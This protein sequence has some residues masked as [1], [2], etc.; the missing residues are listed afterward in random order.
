[1]TKLSATIP[2]A[3][4]VTGIM[5]TGCSSSEAGAPEPTDSADT[6][7]A[8]SDGASGDLPH[9]GAPAV[10]QPIDTKPW[11]SDPCS[12]I[13]ASQFSSIGFD[14][15]D[16]EQ[17]HNA[18]SGPT[19][20]WYPADATLGGFSG[21]FATAQPPSEGLSRIYEKRQHGEYEVWQELD[22]IAGHPVVRAES[23]DDADQ[24]EC[25]LA[26]GLRD[27]LVYAVQVTDEDKEITRDPCAFARKIATLAVETM[28]GGA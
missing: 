11:E 10:Q 2:A 8:T 3:L 13:T 16:A 4:V 14:E 12:V 17:N 28:K 19:C 23:Q 22:N 5:L 7:S 25:G 26:V 9:S 24:G 27:D 1:M 6:T 21:A 15:V 20:D 18:M